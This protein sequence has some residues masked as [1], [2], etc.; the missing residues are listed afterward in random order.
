MLTA[1]TLTARVPP[2]L[3]HQ[4]YLVRRGAAA[5]RYLRHL[6]TAPAEQLFPGIEELE[7]NMQ[8]RFENRG[9]PHGDAYVLSLIT[10]YLRPGRIFEIGT[11]TGRATLLMLRQAPGALVDTLDLGDDNRAELGSERSDLP[12][13]GSRVGEAWLGTEYAGRVSQH[14]GDS[15]RFD[16]SQFGAEMDL[17]LVD[18]AHTADYAARDSRTAL[19]LVRPGGTIVWDD[20]HLMHA[21]VSKA[22]VD[23]RRAGHPVY[24]VANSRLAALRVAG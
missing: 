1:K 13:E 11:G 23:L 5:A 7:I 20:C 8:H 12:I 22:L 24:R 16:F 18:G 3:R 19:R 14:F 6:P 15:A 2:E 9:L 17:V 10:A 4:V 21:G